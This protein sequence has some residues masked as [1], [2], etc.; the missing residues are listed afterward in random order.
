MNTYTFIN[1]GRN[2][3]AEIPH[4]YQPVS[5]AEICEIVRK[6]RKIR[7]VGAGHSWSELC[8]SE[9]SLINL[10]KYNKVISIDKQNHIARIQ[11]GIRIYELNKELDKAGMAFIN[12]GSY[13]K[14]SVAGALST[15]THGTG[16][17]YQIL[18]SQV[19]SYSLIKSDG[20]VEEID[21]K[22]PLFYAAITGLGSLGIISEISLNITPTFNIDDETLAVPFEEAVKNI[23]KW[24]KEYDHFKMWWIPHTGKM[25]VFKHNRTSEKERYTQFGN[26]FKLIFLAEHMYRVLLFVGHLWHK[27]R[28]ICN[29]LMISSYSKPFRRIQKSHE[30]FLVP[31]PPV[32]RE[33]EW[34]FDIEKAEDL[35]REYHNLIENSQH[36]INFIQEIRF[37]KGDNFMLSPCYRKDSVWIGAYLIG[38]KGWDA[39]FTDFEKFARKHDGRPHWGKEFTPDKNYLL[40]LY[41]LYEEFT[42]LKKQLDP[43]GKFENTLIEKLF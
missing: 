42:N 7:M 24:V 32:H 19:E 2:I 34:A 31:E 13:D 28:P 17:N 5:E 33:T 20:S 25:I 29:K 10:D 27:L 37:T 11:S 26:W 36:K 14:Q 15:C 22:H 9:E 1:W 43:Q 30:V 21:E 8:V 16:I 18:A 40:N 12:L 4:Y 23:R 38:N 35:L 6:S 3:K 41:P 39:L